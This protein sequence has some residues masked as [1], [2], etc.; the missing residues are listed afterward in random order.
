MHWE[1]SLQYE[2]RWMNRSALNYY[3]C[4]DVLHRKMA[5]MERVPNLRKVSMSPFINPDEA[6]ANVGNRYVFSYK[7]N[8]ARLWEWARMASEV[9]ERYS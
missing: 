8:P 3:G 6:V 5:I 4:C 2:L 9:T 1:S 7:P